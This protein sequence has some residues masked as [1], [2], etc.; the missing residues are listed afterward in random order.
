MESNLFINGDNI[1]SSVGKIAMLM[2]NNVAYFSNNAEFEH[3]A[4]VG[5][6]KLVLITKVN[7]QRGI[8]PDKETIEKLATIFNVEEYELYTYRKR[9]VIWNPYI[10]NITKNLFE[11]T[12]HIRYPCYVW[13]SKLVATRLNNM[14]SLFL[15]TWKKESHQLFVVL[16]LF[17]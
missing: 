13:L 16:E 2:L 5:D 9:K 14:S 11:T 6:K 10:I 1:S 12:L 8:I 15:K 7:L 17:D 4:S 3:N